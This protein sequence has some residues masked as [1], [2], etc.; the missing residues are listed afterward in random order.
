MHLDLVDNIHAVFAVNH[1][2]GKPP[3]A[4]ASRAA[5]PV[6]VC[7]IVGVPIHVHGEVKVHNERHL[8]DIDTCGM[9][10]NGFWD[11]NT[12]LPA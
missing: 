4:E 10:A 3:P 8:L 5:D 9:A 1:V 2:D 7:L 12:D 11:A 6:K